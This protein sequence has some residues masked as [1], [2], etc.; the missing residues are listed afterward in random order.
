[1]PPT[2]ENNPHIIVWRTIGPLLGLI[3]QRSSGQDA[4][5][6]E[7]SFEAQKFC[8][9]LIELINEELA[10]FMTICISP[11]QPPNSI[12]L[13]TNKILG[14]PLDG[15]ARPSSIRMQPK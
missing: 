3:R 1:M 9:T 15:I 5:L 7:D 8:G 4:L 14:H 10:L 6:E 2:K 13:Y 11:K 12:I